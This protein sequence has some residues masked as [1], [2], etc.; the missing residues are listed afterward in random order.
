MALRR[1]VIVLILAALLSL[2]LPTSPAGA[3]GFNCRTI[4]RGGH[5]AEWCA[6]V[7]FTFDGTHKVFGWGRL[8]LPGGRVDILHVCIWRAPSTLIGCKDDPG[9]SADVASAFSSQHG[10]CHDGQNYQ[11]S[12]TGRV[13]WPDGVLGDNHKVTSLWV[14]ATN[15]DCIP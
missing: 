4:T 2:L 8:K 12:M 6:Q 3:A 11:A 9:S 10:P 7:F 5:T 13:R 1:V 14:P 15:G